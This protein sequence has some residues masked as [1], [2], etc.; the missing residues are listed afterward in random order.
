MRVAY[1]LLSHFVPRL[2]SQ[3]LTTQTV[4]DLKENAY[5]VPTDRDIAM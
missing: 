1:F 3:A 4:E 5:Y 2:C